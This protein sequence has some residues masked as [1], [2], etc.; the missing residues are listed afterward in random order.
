MTHR[1]EHNCTNLNLVISDDRP[2]QNVITNHLPF[3]NICRQLCKVGNS[4]RWPGNS[5]MCL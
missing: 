5:Y 1:T 4:N 3:V 2:N